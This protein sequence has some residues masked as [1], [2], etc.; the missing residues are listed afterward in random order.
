MRL[1]RLYYRV[2][3]TIGNDVGRRVKKELELRSKVNLIRKLLL[4]FDLRESHIQLCVN[5]FP[6]DI[7]IDKLAFI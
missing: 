1:C 7:F 4:A 5:V 2:W 6:I 3:C